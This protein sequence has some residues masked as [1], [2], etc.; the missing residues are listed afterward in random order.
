M[1]SAPSRRRKLSTSERSRKL[2]KTIDKLLIEMFRRDIDP[3][4][5]HAFDE[6][7]TSC[8]SISFLEIEQRWERFVAAIDAIH[9]AMSDPMEPGAWAALIAAQRL[10][11]RVDETLV[12]VANIGYAVATEGDPFRIDVLREFGVAVPLRPSS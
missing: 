4:D 11:E 2:A 7:T 1:T 12:L 5:A 10:S 3:D 8:L 6:N 9:H